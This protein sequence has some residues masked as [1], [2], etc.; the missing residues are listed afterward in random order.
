MSV[1]GSNRYTA[2]LV[3]QL[4]KDSNGSAR[5]LDPVRSSAVRVR[6]GLMCRT[7]SF[8]GDQKKP[9]GS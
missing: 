3:R 8:F 9:A 5:T 4:V 7:S 2:G 1:N 6:H